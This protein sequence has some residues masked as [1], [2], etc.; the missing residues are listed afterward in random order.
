M[1]EAIAAPVVPTTPAQTTAPAT[2]P[3]P[4]ETKAAPINEEEYRKLR[5]DRD[6]RVK[7]YVTEKRAWEGEKKTFGEKLSK[8]TE[9]EQFDRLLQ[10]NPLAALEKRLGPNAFERLS[11]M[12]A[13]GT[14]PADMIAEQIERMRG[15]VEAKFTAQEQ[16]RKDA[17]VNEAKANSER[18]R[19][20]LTS[21][22]REFYKGAL[23]DYPI[24]AKFGDEATVAATLAQRIEAEFHRT[25]QRDPET[26][27][28]LR[29]GK[30]MTVREAADLIEGELLGI[31]EEAAAHEKYRP[32]ISARLQ[33]VKEAATVPAQQTQQ[34]K[35]SQNAERQQRRTLSNQLTGSTQE[36]KPSLTPAERR[37]RA[38][39]AFNTAAAKRG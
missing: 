35:D 33:P 12:K 20:Q 10:T 39:A 36:Q 7:A 31:A 9:L 28:T 11:E 1:P 6:R 26:G 23:K 15:E 2:P 38:V 32:K 8:L 17:A 37:A 29:L 4:V 19:R 18:A 14:M 3:A 27:E 13:N 16:A 24:F 34:P 25:T 30:V 5:L 21:E 22:A